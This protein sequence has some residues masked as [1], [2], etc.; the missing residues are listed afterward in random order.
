ME[1][2]DSLEDRSREVDHV[3]TLDS[4]DQSD[5][6]RSIETRQRGHAGLPGVD[7]I[8]AT[9]TTPTKQQKSIDRW[10]SAIVNL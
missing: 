6:R 4:W 9:R 1:A 3:A 5:L 8:C 7:P 2:M 10:N